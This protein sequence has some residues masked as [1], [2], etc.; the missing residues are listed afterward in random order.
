M[1]GERFAER[2]P[3]VGAR[4]HAF[5][6]ALRQADQT[7][8]MVDAAGPETALCDLETTA[9]AEDQIFRRHAHLIEYDFGVAVRRVVIAEHGERAHDLHAG[10]IA[11]HQDHRRGGDAARRRDW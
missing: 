10:R 3:R 5:E 1:C 11:R 4:D 6:R 9:F 2:D 8:A 7:H